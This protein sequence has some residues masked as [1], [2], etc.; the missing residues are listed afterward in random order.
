MTVYTPLINLMPSDPS[1][2]MTTSVEADKITNQRT[3]NTPFLPAINNFA[4]S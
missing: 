1:T 3:E 4:R 2:M